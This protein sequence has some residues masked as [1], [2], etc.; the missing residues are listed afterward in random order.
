MSDELM[1]TVTFGREGAKRSF[2]EEAFGPSAPGAP[3]IELLQDPLLRKGLAQAWAQVHGREAHALEQALTNI[4]EEGVEFFTQPAPLQAYWAD[5]FHT[6]QRGRH[7]LR[8]YVL[9]VKACRSH[10]FYILSHDEASGQTELL[11]PPF[12]E[13]SA[14]PGADEGAVEKLRGVG[15]TVLFLAP[16][17]TQI[18]AK[19]HDSDAESK[20]VH[21][22]SWFDIKLTCTVLE[23]PPG[24]LTLRVEPD[25]GATAP[26][27]RLGKLR[28]LMAS[29]NFRNAVAALSEVWLNPHARTVLLCAWTGSGKEV[30]VDLLAEALRIRRRINTSA[31]ALGKFEALSNRLEKASET[32][33]LRDS[34]GTGSP[35]SDKT[36][37]FIDEVHHEAAADLRPGLLRLLSADRLET[38]SG[39]EF[40]CEAILYVLAAS[41]SPD[42]LRTRVAPK[43]LWTRMEHTVKYKH[44]F[45]LDSEEERQEVL[46][47][48]FRF[49]WELREEKFKAAAKEVDPDALSIV[50]TEPGSGALD[51]KSVA[52]ALENSLVATLRP[53]LLPLLSVRILNILVTRLF[54]RAVIHLRRA[55]FGPPQT[56]SDSMQKQFD[57]WVK[58]LRDELAS[59]LASD[60]AEALLRER[61]VF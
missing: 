6:V 38:A 8:R 32:L 26:D 34:T 7:G 12:F 61:G 24:S 43:D 46:R 22:L 14:P 4:A 13:S 21:L 44:P 37:L 18:R 9:R 30:L 51:C 55:S 11:R 27:V 10:Y 40:L 53:E 57:G 17:L 35:S 41:E 33:L 48:Y 20:L 54:N 49:F 28:I 1:L 29:P 36:L 19:L 50:L 56:H 31:A 5:L 25:L 3:A 42:S 59:E 60:P 47:Q 39:R 2:G 52:Q 15:D 58:E 45:Y 23:T 16:A